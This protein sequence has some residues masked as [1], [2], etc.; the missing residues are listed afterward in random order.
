MEDLDLE[1]LTDVCDD[2]RTNWMWIKLLLFWW[3]I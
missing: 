3:I 2:P 1:D